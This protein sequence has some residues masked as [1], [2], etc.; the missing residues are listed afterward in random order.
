MVEACP[1][2]RLWTHL[3]KYKKAFDSFITPS[4]VKK[5][6]AGQVSIQLGM[7]NFK[8]HFNWEGTVLGDGPASHNQSLPQSPHLSS[9]R[10]CSSPPPP[11]SVPLDRALSGEDSNKFPEEEG[12]AAACVCLEEEEEEEKEALDLSA[13]R[14]GPTQWRIRLP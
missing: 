10:K 13:L 8:S 5:W 3:K 4:S 12:T 1:V 9:F 14:G 6:A 2:A 7:N 11:I